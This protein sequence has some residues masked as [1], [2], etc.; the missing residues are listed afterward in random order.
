MERKLVT[1][2]K[3]AKI[4]PIE[5]ADA[6][7]CLTVDGWKIV[8]KKGEFAE[9]DNCVFF[10]IDSILPD[11][12][13]FKFLV[14][15]NGKEFENGRGARLRTIKLRG[16]VSQGL[17]LPVALFPEVT[18]EMNRLLDDPEFGGSVED[19][20]FDELV[21]VYKYEPKI[22]ANM[23]GQQR[24]NYPHWLPKTDQERVQNCYGAYVRRGH[25]ENSL[26][27]AEEKLEG[28]SMTIYVDRDG[29]NGVTS[30][31]IDLKLDQEGNI[32]VDAAKA[33]GLL[34][35]L[36]EFHEIGKA[37]QPDEPP[38]IAI[39]GE[40]IGPG[41]QGNIYGL[42]ENEFRV[43]DVY[44]GNF[45][46]YMTPQERAMFIETLKMAGYDVYQV[47]ELGFLNLNGATVEQ[48]IDFANG[49]SALADT[50][51]EGIVF[52]S[53]D[54]L[55]GNVVSFKSISAEYLLNEK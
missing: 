47:P 35:A 34:D 51:R 37:D 52:K 48:I 50:A 1:I 13:P 42:E 36:K 6:I 46:R 49:Q 28:S 41:I 9:G 3:V 44:V 33:S 20:G 45:R 10:E 11:R 7:E 16:Q 25:F 30:R 18:E 19:M 2:R 29:E 27:C 17:A 54:V 32:F 22:S 39:R 14:D 21:G 5:K 53:V 12:E 55:D 40:L 31:N 24:G 43:F 15:K 38:A 8:S 26:W 23:A 4:E